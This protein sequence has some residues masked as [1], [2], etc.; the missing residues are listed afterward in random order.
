MHDE[1]TIYLRSPS[2]V[3]ENSESDIFSGCTQKMAIT[4]IGMCRAVS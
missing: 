4:V 3:Q 1:N 2:T